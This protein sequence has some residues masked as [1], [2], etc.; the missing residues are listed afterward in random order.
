MVAKTGRQDCSS[1]LLLQ[2]VSGD[3]SLSEA[4]VGSRGFATGCS[5]A[6]IFC[7]LLVTLS[8]YN[9]V[10]NVCYAPE[11]RTKWLLGHRFREDLQGYLHCCAGITPEGPQSRAAVSAQLYSQITCTSAGWVMERATLC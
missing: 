3:K 10:H 6:R 5:S 2:T 8:P 9:Y 4:P 7:P 11:G 1:L